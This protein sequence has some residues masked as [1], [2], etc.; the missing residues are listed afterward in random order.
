MKVF[1]NP[2][3]LMQSSNN[4]L[5][6]K[7]FFDDLCTINSSDFDLSNNDIERVSRFD[8]DND[9]YA[10]LFLTTNKRNGVCGIKIRNGTR[11]LIREL[12][13]QEIGEF[14]LL[15]LRKDTLRGVYIHYRGG[16]S[17]SHLGVLTKRVFAN[18]TRRKFKS[19]KRSEN[20]EIV[21]IINNSALID[22]IEKFSKIISI[23][24]GFTYKSY[25]RGS[26]FVP[27]TG[28][29]L[30]RSKRVKIEYKPDNIFDKFGNVDPDIIKELSEAYNNG[31]CSSMSMSGEVHGLSMPE[32][33]NILETVGHVNIEE[34]D[35]VLKMVDTCDFNN[36]ITSK[37]FSQTKNLIYNGND[38]ALFL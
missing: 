27:S 31:L 18:K 32:S 5:S 37:L 23:N 35:D 7:D 9:V 28:R 34:F 12:L 26:K 25:A 19:K 3:A 2:V 22:K 38:K 24:M 14:N 30:D 20:L 21:N 16:L 1:T 17:P 10:A 8:K 13:T 33:I 6:V 4:R 36:F 29:L 15:M 11:Y